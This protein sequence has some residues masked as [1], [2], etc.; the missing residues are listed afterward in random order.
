[1]S[2]DDQAEPSVQ[3]Q[4]LL[5]KLDRALSSN[6]RATLRA[7]ASAVSLDVL[8]GT[9]ALG[10]PTEIQLLLKWH[11]G[12]EWNAPLSGKNNRRLM[13][14]SEIAEQIMFFSDP[15]EDFL[16]P[17]ELSWIPI[18]TN[19]SGDFV[20][21]QT[22]GPQPGA[23]SVYWHDDE[24]RGVVYPSLKNW[25]QELLNEYTGAEA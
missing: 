9:F 12:Q 15:E 17:W 7:P 11:D 16:E 19:D 21:Y 3:L 1:M 5:E 8:A 23:L 13:P 24:M 14:A 22:Q 2:A 18:L 20:V 4:V 10:L 6:V 25:V